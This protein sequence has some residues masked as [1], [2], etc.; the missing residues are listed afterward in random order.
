MKNQDR[1]IIETYERKNELESL[2]YQ[3]KDRLTKSHQQYAKPEEI[4]PILAFL[5][6]TSA[7]LY[8][9]GQNANRGTY[10]N[11]IDAVKQKVGP[12]NKRYENFLKIS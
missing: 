1:L 8:D 7:W 5:E 6:E 10:A 11:K 4:Q 9:E 12:I 3:W 2:I